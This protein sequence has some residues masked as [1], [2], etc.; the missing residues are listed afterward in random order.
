M[1]IVQFK[2]QMRKFRNWICS[3]LWKIIHCNLLDDNSFNS[4]VKLILVKVHKYIEVI[5]LGEM[6]VIG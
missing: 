5:V 2:R 4:L 3:S 1:G 6:E